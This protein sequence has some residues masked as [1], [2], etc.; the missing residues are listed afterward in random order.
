M[1]PPDPERPGPGAPDPRA[2]PD[3]RAA[4]REAASAARSLARQLGILGAGAARAALR[5]RKSVV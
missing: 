1:N 3:T 5:D 2:E 4:A